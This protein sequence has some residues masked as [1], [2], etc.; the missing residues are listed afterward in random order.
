MY[1]VN[2]VSSCYATAVIDMQIWYA[3]FS[4]V[5]G[6]FIIIRIQLEEVIFIHLTTFYVG[7][8]FCS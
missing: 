3:T 5:V 7:L 8:D 2:A 4:T 1:R 6:G